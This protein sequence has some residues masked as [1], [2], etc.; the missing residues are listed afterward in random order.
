MD[1]YLKTWRAAS[2]AVWA[3]EGLIDRHETADLLGV[4]VRTL[5]RWHHDG[6]GPKRV[7]GP[8]RGHLS[9]LYRRSEVE[10]WMSTNMPHLHKEAPHTTLPLKSEEVDVH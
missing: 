10:K 1:T 6:S 7:P 9:V 3:A 2:K 4:T 8:G 5:Q